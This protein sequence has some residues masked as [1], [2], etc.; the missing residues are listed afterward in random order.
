MSKS[1]VGLHVWTA[2]GAPAAQAL[3]VAAVETRSRAFYVIV[4]ARPH[5]FLAPVLW[6]WLLPLLDIYHSATADPGV[7]QANPDPIH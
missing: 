1:Q 2:S 3:I 6:R 4:A 5:G 7:G